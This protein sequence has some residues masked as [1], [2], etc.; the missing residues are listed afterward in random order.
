MKKYLAILLIAIMATTVLSAA[1]VVTT[2]KVAAVPSSTPVVVKYRPGATYI[3]TPSQF[4][5]RT[6][7]N[8]G[9]LGSKSFAATFN[10]ALRT[11]AITTQIGQAAQGDAQIGMAWRLTLPSHGPYSNWA[12]VVTLPCRVTVTLAYDVSANGPNINTYA[13]A[14]ALVAHNAQGAT[15]FGND[16]I[17]TQIGIRRLTFVSSVG[18]V[19]SSGG[20]VGLARIQAVSLMQDVGQAHASLICSSIVLEF[21]AS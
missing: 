3:F 15:V 20:F 16:P 8:F 18:Q 14:R 10:N 19:F 9:S 2:Q 13:T 17:H 6:S 4:N 21:P 7:V 5:V 1:G 12:Y 11:Y